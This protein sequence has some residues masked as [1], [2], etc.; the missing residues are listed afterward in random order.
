MQRR[1]RARRAALVAPAVAA[2]LAL[3]ARPALAAAGDLDSGFGKGGRVLTAVGSSG[4]SSASAVLTQPD[5]KVLAAGRSGSFPYDVTIVR[6]RSDGT[7]DASFG[8]GGIATA[9]VGPSTDV[10]DAAALQP[11]GKILVAGE[12][13][14][15][16]GNFDFAVVRFNPN[17]TLDTTFGTGGYVSWDIL[18]ENNYLTSVTVAPNGRIAVAGWTFH[19]IGTTDMVVGRLMPDGSQ[20][21]AF[22]VG[23]FAPTVGFHSSGGE[24]AIGPGGRLILAGE[25]QYTGNVVVARWLGNGQ[26][27]TSFGGGSGHVTFTYG[28]D[29]GVTGVAVQPDSKILVAGSPFMPS[30]FNRAFGLARLNLDGSLDDTF[31]VTGPGYSFVDF[32]PADD[33]V[34]GMA[35]AADG[36]IAL[37]GLSSAGSHDVFG[38]ARVT[39]DGAPDASFGVGGRVKTG[40]GGSNVLV[41]QAQG[42]AV[43]ADGKIVAAGYV[44]TFT[45][46]RFALARY[47]AA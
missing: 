5:G 29:P 34:L 40:F 20:D 39:A 17:G 9:H 35:L 22:P 12:I 44:Q 25:E 24:V 7:R 46:Q 11:D 18:A 4:Y 32:G 26:V 27:D 41:I 1:L 33:Q 10:V 47:L 2:V 23:I 19:Q 14:N 13:D 45:G 8:S 30:P 38:V 15:T 16:S 36:T 42:V 37:A 3:A 43:Q 31:G 21:P 28:V 6:Y